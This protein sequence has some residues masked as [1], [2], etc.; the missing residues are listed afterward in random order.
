MRNYANGPIVH[1]HP[2]GL[3]I[4]DKIVTFGRR[5]QEKSS[6]Y[7]VVITLA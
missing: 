5:I 3:T 2:N 7:Y 6:N 4:L 1:S